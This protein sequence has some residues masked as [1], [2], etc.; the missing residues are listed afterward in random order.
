M[1]LGNDNYKN[2]NSV[3][4]NTNDIVDLK[5]LS[6]LV[7]F[8]VNYIKKELLI[9]DDLIKVDALREVALKFLKNT[10]EEIEILH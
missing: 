6:E 7:G 1:V 2:C 10:S 4:E 3:S 8:P 5:D 9:V